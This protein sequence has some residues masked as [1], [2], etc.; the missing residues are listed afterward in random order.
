M[1]IHFKNHIILF[2]SC[3]V[4]LELIHN[5]TSSPHTNP[6]ISKKHTVCIL[7][8]NKGHFFKFCWL[9][10]NS[11]IIWYYL[12]AIFSQKKC[13]NSHYCNQTQKL[14][15]TFFVKKK[16]THNQINHPW[17]VLDVIKRGDSQYTISYLYMF[18]WRWLLGESFVQF[19]Q[20]HF[21]SAFLNLLPLLIFFF[22]F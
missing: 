5:V 11:I 13:C 21:C 7:V 4:I 10:E 2:I 3:Y 1:F 15:S 22:S 9:R 19:L 16:T 20:I 12:Q 8:E 18:I 14:L 6:K 17:R